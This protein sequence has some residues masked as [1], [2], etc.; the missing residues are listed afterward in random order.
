MK[1]PTPEEMAE[2]AGRGAAPSPA[3]VGA[4][5]CGV[6]A[7]RKAIA[8]ALEEEAKELDERSFRGARFHAAAR[9]QIAASLR[10][11]R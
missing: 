10:G 5:V 3:E 11:A 7:A 8:A 4:F 6:R 2:H 1:L 9:R